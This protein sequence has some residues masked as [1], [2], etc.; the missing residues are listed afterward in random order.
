[1]NV[2]EEGGGGIARKH[3]NPINKA[4]AWEGGGGGWVGGVMERDRFWRGMVA[5][6]SYHTV[7]FCFRCG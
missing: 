1:M 5:L 6:H 2:A 4:L 7:E 3:R